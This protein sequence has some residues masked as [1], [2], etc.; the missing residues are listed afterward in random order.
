MWHHN[1][2]PH[3]SVRF[4]EWKKNT[5]EHSVTFRHWRL[6]KIAGFIRR[7]VHW[8]CNK[9]EMSIAAVAISCDHI[10]A[11]F[12]VYTI[13]KVLRFHGTVAGFQFLLRLIIN[14]NCYSGQISLKYS[15]IVNAIKIDK[16]NKFAINLCADCDCDEKG[17]MFWIFSV[18]KI[19]SYA[20]RPFMEM[21]AV[22]CTSV[23]TRQN[24]LD[25]YLLLTYASCDAVVSF[26]IIL[27]VRRYFLLLLLLRWCQ[28]THFH[29]IKV[30]NANTAI[31]TIDTWQ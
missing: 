16:N 5:I 14:F 20:P 31:I 29:L 6:T 3:C 4:H 30:F 22:H 25:Y 21:E 15:P 24:C 2:V 28:I 26:T 12:P 18:I 13:V 10:N 23:N 19:R 11:F 8:E 7:T 9:Y 1:N 17:R 27:V